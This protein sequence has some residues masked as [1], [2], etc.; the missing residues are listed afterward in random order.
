[1]I[2]N[3]SADITND[4]RDDYELCIELSEH[5]EHKSTIQRNAE[6]AL[7][8][9]VFSDPKTLCIPVTWLLGVL[10]RAERELPARSGAL[11]ENET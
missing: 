7:V 9:E 3:W 4:P 10:E 11:R 2:H 6:G 5:G 1:M 8:M